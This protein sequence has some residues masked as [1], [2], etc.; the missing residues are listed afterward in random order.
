MNE[1]DFQAGSIILG[2]ESVYI[3]KSLNS[4]MAY[5]LVEGLTANEVQEIFDDDSPYAVKI[6]V[7]YEPDPTSVL[8]ELPPGSV[9]VGGDSVVAIKFEQDWSVSGS[10]SWFDS[11]ALMKSLG[12]RFEVVRRGGEG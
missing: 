12:G 3:K 5:D 9:V 1:S 11:G 10:E 6:E 7:L 2:Y 8:V 4:W